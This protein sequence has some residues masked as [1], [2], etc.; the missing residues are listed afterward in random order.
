MERMS[1][2]G[3]RGWSATQI[4]KTKRTRMEVSRPSCD[5]GPIARR[6]FGMMSDG[7][8]LFRFSSHSFFLSQ[9]DPPIVYHLLRLARAC[10]LPQ[11]GSCS[12]KD[13]RLCISGQE[14]E[15]EAS[16]RAWVSHSPPRLVSIKAADVS[17][18]LRLSFLATSRT[19]T[20][21]QKTSSRFVSLIPVL[22]PS[23]YT[24]TH[25]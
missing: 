19:T 10:L 1:N 16:C 24:D 18:S 7:I 23:A 4:A 6:P 5:P 13:A 25:L 3:R 11:E 22:L 9:P 17:L 12:Q 15:E 2:G 20:T 8:L 21:G 14:Q